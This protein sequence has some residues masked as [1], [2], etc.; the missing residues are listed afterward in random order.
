MIKAAKIVQTFRR[1]LIGLLLIGLWLLA[2]IPGSQAQSGSQPLVFAFY[3]TWYDEN[4]WRPDRVPDMP[5]EPYVSRDPQVM[6]RHIQQ[7]RSA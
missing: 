1:A 6:A 2:G 5:L 7:A 3:Y 4:T